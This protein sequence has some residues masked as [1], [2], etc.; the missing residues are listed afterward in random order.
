MIGWI[1][2]L[3]FT[4]QPDSSPL[5][6]GHYCLYA[7]GITWTLISFSRSPGYVHKF[8]ALFNQ[9]FRCFVV[10]TLVMVIFTGVYFK[11]HP[12]FATQSAASYREYLVKEDKNKTPA[13]VDAAVAEHKDR[14]NTVYVS[15]SVMGYLI[16]GAIFTVAGAALLLMRRRN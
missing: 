7:G 6:F 10:V 12:E 9:G 14:F 8:G 2:L 1:L 5:Q 13:E 4:N 3:Y 15:A 16:T 11:M